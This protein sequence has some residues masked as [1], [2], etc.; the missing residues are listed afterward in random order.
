MD[1]W[2][3]IVGTHGNH[4]L[5]RL[6]LHLFRLKMDSGK[7]F[8]PYHVFG[9][10]WKIWSN[11]KTFPLTVKRTHFSRKVNYTLILPL[12]DFQDSHRERERERRKS[13]GVRNPSPLSSTPCTGVYMYPIQQGKHLPHASEAHLTSNISDLSLPRRRR[14]TSLKPTLY[15]TRSTQDWSRSRPTQDRS[16][17]RH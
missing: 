15:N 3:I 11:G 5:K 16:H 9:C 10:A 13:T 6:R 8:T 2:Q 1:T 7:Q 12:N 4:F 14:N 17:C